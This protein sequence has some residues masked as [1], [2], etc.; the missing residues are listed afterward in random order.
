[1]KCH[2]ITHAGARDLQM[3]VFGLRKRAC[4][5]RSRVGVTRLCRKR[6][7]ER[8]FRSESPPPGCL[9]CKLRQKCASDRISATRDVVEKKKCVRKKKEM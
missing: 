6:E 1:M 9:N 2:A 5:V 3:N 8:E 4:R 7:S